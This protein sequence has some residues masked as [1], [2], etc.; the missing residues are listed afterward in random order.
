MSKIQPVR[1]VL[2]DLMLREFLTAESVALLAAFADPDIG[3]WN[4]QTT[5]RAAV[6]AWAAGRNDWSGGDHASWAIA[7]GE[8]QLVGSVS[9]HHI[10]RE[11]KDAE[12]GYWVAPWARGRGF[13]RLAAQAAAGFGFQTLGLHRIYLHH[14]VQ[15]AASCAVATQ[16]GF[17][18]EG[19]L[20]ESHLYGDG[21]RHDE[22][23]HARLSGDGAAQGS[24]VT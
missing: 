24:V 19:T 4:P 8:D 11:Q 12:L 1:V 18:L 6:A 3:L 21:V 13:A 2:G 14:A 9:L 17:Q 20:C 15:N 5:D 10:D 23:L 7:D 22:H 16:A